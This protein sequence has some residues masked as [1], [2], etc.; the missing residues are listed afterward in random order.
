M[1]TI[2]A[3][4]D[5]HDYKIKKIIHNQCII[6]KLPDWFI[7]TQ[8]IHFI[9]CVSLDKHDHFFPIKGR[10]LKIDGDNFYINFI[11]F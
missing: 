5:H 2:Y 8:N 6:E 7:A 4:S 3:T 10:I 1:I 11:D 9:I